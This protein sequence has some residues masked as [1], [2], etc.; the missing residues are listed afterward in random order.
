MHLNRIL[1]SK[2]RILTDSNLKQLYRNPVQLLL[3]YV[4]SVNTH[5]WVRRE[6]NGQ[7]Y[8]KF[9]KNLRAPDQRSVGRQWQ[10]VLKS[11]VKTCGF[12]V[13]QPK[14]KA[15]HKCYNI[16]TNYGTDGILLSPSWESTTVP[17]RISIL[18]DVPINTTLLYAICA[19]IIYYV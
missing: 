9:T 12:F 8:L 1:R 17:K 7:A 14:Y 4:F 5:L 3:L 10:F 11:H 16:R 13:Y 2:R 15:E 19:H 18:P 6:N